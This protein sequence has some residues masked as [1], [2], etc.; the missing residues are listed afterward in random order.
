MYLF[1]IW[2]CGISD[3]AMFFDSLSL[4]CSILSRVP[5]TFGMSGEATGTS[6]PAYAWDEPSN[7]IDYIKN[8]CI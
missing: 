6:L 4:L 3:F 5:S 1:F 7:H 8:I 2:L